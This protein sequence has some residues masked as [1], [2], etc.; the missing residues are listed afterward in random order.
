MA[1]SRRAGEVAPAKLADQ[2]G[3]DGVVQLGLGKLG[4]VLEGGGA[5]PGPFGLGDPQLHA[6]QLPAVVAGGLLGVGDAVPGGHE[7]ELA[8]AG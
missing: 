3:G 2:D 1:V 8:G 5:V 4:V 6:V 7:V